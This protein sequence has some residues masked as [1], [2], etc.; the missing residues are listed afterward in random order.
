[1]G[2]LVPASRSMRMRSWRLAGFVA[3][4]APLASY[5]KRDG[6]TAQKPSQSGVS[7]HCLVEGDEC[8]ELGDTPCDVGPFDRLACLH[9]VTLQLPK[10]QTVEKQKAGGR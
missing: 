7:S 2:T 5:C 8:T 3:G 1:M 4:F 10:C 9:H 6:T